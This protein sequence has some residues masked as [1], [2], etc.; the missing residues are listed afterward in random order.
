MRKKTALQRFEENICYAGDCIAWV[1]MTTRHGYGWVQIN[2]GKKVKRMMAH[3]FAWELTNG[4]VPEGLV[5][6]H[7]C[8][9]KG[10]VNPAHL[11]PVTNAENVR[12]G[13]KFI[14][15]CPRGHEYTPENTYYMKRNRT[16]RKCR[17]CH[18][19][20]E[21]ERRRTKKLDG[22]EIWRKLG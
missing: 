16:H 20:Q 14:T 4:K 11:E 3:K 7:V 15:H 22:M 6:D 18:R 21:Y 5:L 9:N 13:A 1:G 10:C 12:R 17:A 2:H 19:D 8:R